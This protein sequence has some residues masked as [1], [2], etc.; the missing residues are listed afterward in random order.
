MDENIFNDLKSGLEEAK[1]YKSGELKVEGATFKIKVPDVK[2]I[3]TQAGMTQE[4]FASM[5]RWSLD[6]V[7]SWEQGRRVP[8]QSAR[9]LLAL[10]AMDR[11]YMEKSLSKL[12]TA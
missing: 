5:F 1:A 12:M 6:T 2:A 3:R 8:D 7:R 11:Q 10:F 9:I 4:E